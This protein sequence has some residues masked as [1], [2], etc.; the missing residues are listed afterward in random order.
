[1]IGVFKLIIYTSILENKIKNYINKSYFAI[2]HPLFSADIAS[3]VQP[4]L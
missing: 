3:T 4:W 2:I 1:M